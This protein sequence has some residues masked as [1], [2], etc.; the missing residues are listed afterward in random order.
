MPDALALLS[1]GQALDAGS[2]VE[3]PH[4]GATGGCSRASADGHRGEE[5]KEEEDCSGVMHRSCHVLGALQGFTSLA[6]YNAYGY[7]CLV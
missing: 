3:L 4:S 1:R 6:K 7:N 2:Y 5:E